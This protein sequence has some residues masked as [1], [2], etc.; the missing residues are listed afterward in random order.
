MEQTG[1]YIMSVAADLMGLHPSTLRLW[2]RKGLLTPS[3]TEGGTRLYSDANLAR[4]R[5]IC[6]LTDDR[7]NLAG[8]ARILELEDELAALRSAPPAP[9]DDGDE[10]AAAPDMQTHDAPAKPVDPDGARPDCNCGRPE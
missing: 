10:Y 9:L 7:V 1:L 5:R 4:M 8:I 3:R 6:A 2:E